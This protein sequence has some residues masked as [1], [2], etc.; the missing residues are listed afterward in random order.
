MRAL[1]VFALLASCGAAAQDSPDAFEITQRFAASG[2][3]QTALTRIAQLQPATPGAPRWGD[4]EQ[5]RCELMARLS[6]HQELAQRVAALPS[7]V[8]DKVARSCLLQGARAA[9]AVAQGATARD[10]LARLIWR[11]EPIADELRQARLLVIESYLAEHKP[12]DAYALML[13]YQQ[14]L[15][16]V[17]RDA[18]ARFVE[19][20]L[21]AGMGQEAVNWLSQLD[22]ASPLKLQLRL[23]ASLIAPAAAIAQAR[24]ALARTGNSA[25]WW[26]V[27]QHAASV[28]KDRTLLVEAL[29]NLLQL[30]G[31]KPPERLAALITELWQSYAA[32][33]QDAANQNQLLVGDDA[34][35]A[36]YAS[37]RAAASPAV[38][39]AFFAYLA[40]QST[41]GDTRRNAQL[42]L[43]FSLQQ[44]KLGLTALRLFGDAAR[45]PVAQLDPQARYL[46]GSM[47]LE[48]NQPLTAARYW[49]G[50]DTPPTL[51]PDEW[52]I[53]LAQVLVRAGA[54]GPGAA[55]LRALVA[56]SKALSPGIMQRAVA[57]VQELQDGGHASTADEL[58]RALLPLAAA[59]LRREILF[60]RGRIAEAN[61]DF[62]RAADYLL[63][64]ALLIDSRATDALAVNARL[65][66]A[67]NLGRAGLKDDAR[68]Q[69]NW[70]QKNVKDPEWLEL[71][72]REMQKL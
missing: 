36:D 28:Q 29:E 41:F 37:R 47:A 45:F 60:G 42:Q 16:P 32:A 24:A 7:S 31:D 34:N 14:D 61:K 10:F 6:R 30:A 58:Y 1:A 70:L 67:A 27:A 43:A 17:D 33:A 9:I 11:Q 5:L 4:W 55:A 40:Q 56:G 39:R 25:A 2:A 65:A 23:K 64:A 71:I 8:P 44:G 63:E 72:R 53:R 51:D 57:A 26:V 69:F 48:N 54:A 35:W 50:L 21:A 20:L 49:Q 22:E 52:R 46:L 62:Q 18:A 59:P 13:R 3:L 38:A 68:S 12:Q 15:K 19:A 66:A